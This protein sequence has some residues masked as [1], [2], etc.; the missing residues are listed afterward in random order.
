MMLDDDSLDDEPEQQSTI[1]ERAKLIRENLL[2]VKSRKKYVT[3][4]ENFIKWSESQG[5]TSFSEDIMLTYFD[6]LTAKSNSPSTLWSYYSMIKSNLR[7]KHNIDIGKYYNLIAFIKRQNEGYEPKKAPVFNATQI[8]QFLLNSSLDHEWLAAKTVAVM[9]LFGALRCDE[10]VKML[11]EHVQK[12]GNLLVVSVPITKTKQAKKF[13]IDKPNFIAIIEKYKSLR[14]PNTPIDRFFLKYE[15]GKCR[16]Q[17]IGINKFY[18]MP[19]Q[20]A[21]FLKLPDPKS[22]TGHTFRR[23]SAS[24]L[25]NQGASKRML[26][27][28]GLWKSAQIAE[29]YVEQS[30]KYKQNTA[31]FLNAALGEND[32]SN[33]H[34]N[35]NERTQNVSGFQPNSTF[36]QNDPAHAVSVGFHQD[37]A[38]EYNN[39]LPQSTS[40]FY[41]TPI[42]IVPSSSSHDPPSEIV[43]SNSYYEEVV[44]IN[45]EESSSTL[46]ETHRSTAPIMN[47]SNCNVTINYNYSK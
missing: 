17:P 45:P 1:S 20:I 35:E 39:Q 43:T 36:H 15:N 4:F 26:Q 41:E 44:I 2:P 25:G 14:P 16:R 24:W 7:L 10:F 13:V 32:D 3:V 12:E 38:P 37:S 28:H 47:F 46:Q 6:Y 9:G 23:S 34:H 19:M 33:V 42:S 40:S 21:E 27:N 18:K 29:S 31:S 30:I 8:R 5:D 22:Y 11:V